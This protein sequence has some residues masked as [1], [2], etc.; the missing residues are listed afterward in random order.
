MDVLRG[1]LRGAGDLGF[2]EFIAR[3]VALWSGMAADAFLATQGD[4]WDTQWDMFL[5]LSGALASQILLGLARPATG[6]EATAE[7]IAVASVGGVLQV[8]A[9]VKERP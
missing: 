8:E 7:G 9:A 1:V 6:V 2:Y 3:W 5:A 4:V